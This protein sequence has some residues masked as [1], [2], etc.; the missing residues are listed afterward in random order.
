MI[1][2]RSEI[3]PEVRAAIE[4][5]LRSLLKDYALESYSIDAGEDYDGDAAIFVVLN[6]E[7]NERAFDAELHYEVRSDISKKLFALG[8]RRYA[9][10]R[11]NLHDG[12]KPKP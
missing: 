7:P 10:V 2:L 9:Y 8:E 4:E 3:R 5:T 6:Y 1:T 11:H 12:Q